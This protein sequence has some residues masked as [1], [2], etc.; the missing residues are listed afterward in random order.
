MTFTASRLTL[1]DWWREFVAEVLS[2]DG[3]LPRTIRALI[4]RPGF[5]ARDWIE[6]ERTRWAS[7]LRLYFIASLLMFGTA[8]L[9]PDDTPIVMRSATAASVDVVKVVESMAMDVEIQRSGPTVLIVL[10]PFFA[11]LT[12]AAFRR[13]GLYYPEHLVFALHAHAVVF[14]TIVLAMLIDLLPGRW[15]DLDI[16]PL[17]AV[18]AWLFLGMKRFFQARAVRTLLLGSSVIVVHVLVVVAALLIVA[19]ARS[20]TSYKQRMRA[21]ELYRQALATPGEAGTQ[22]RLAAFVAYQRLEAHQLTPHVRYHLAQLLLADGAPSAARLMAEEALAR[23][24]EHLL[25]LGIAAETAEAVGDTAAAAAYR[26]R[27]GAHYAAR[28]ADA[29]YREHPRELEAYRAA[30]DSSGK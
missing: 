26:T 1:R 27:L 4:A 5:V 17:L 28:R 21:N 9:L 23:A 7:P 30:A 12:R 24:P 3:R 25:L 22:A 11:L 14:A 2:V 8:A 29:E 20:D 13:A 16:I 15:D 19:A 10:V 6:G 18:L